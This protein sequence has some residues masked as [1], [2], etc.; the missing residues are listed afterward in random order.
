MVLVR[1]LAQ[2]A[3]ADFYNPII[4]FIVRITNPLLIPLRRVIPSIAKFDTASLVLAIV[5]ILVEVVLLKSISYG[6]LTVDFFLEPETYIIVLDRLIGMII[7][8]LLTITSILA[9]LSWLQPS[10][11]HPTVIL[12][13]QLADPLLRPIRRYLPI[14]GIDFSPMILIILLYIIQEITS[15]Y[16]R[17]LLNAIN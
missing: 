14:S 11:H 2:I 4:Q 17:I 3:R 1:L 13:T 15:G 7:G 16:L 5:V 8:L 12:L 10:P 6:I 9:L